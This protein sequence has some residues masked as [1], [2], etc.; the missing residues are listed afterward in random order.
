MVPNVHGIQKTGA[1]AG[2]TQPPA[3]AVASSDAEK[4]L[5]FCQGRNLRVVDV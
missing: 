5:V 2:N 3:L 1:E 4:L